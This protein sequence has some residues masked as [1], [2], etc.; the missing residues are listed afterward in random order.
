[1]PGKST[2]LAK[3]YTKG[4]ARHERGHALFHPVPVEAM[5]AP[6]VG[7]FDDRGKWHL[8]TS[9]ARQYEDPQWSNN[10]YKP[11]RKKPQGQPVA[12]ESWGILKTSDVYDSAIGFNA[13][14]P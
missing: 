1:M 5:K 3:A 11:L 12:T 6:C 8:I 7:Y 9:L 13:G 4:M 14:T 10:E 2:S